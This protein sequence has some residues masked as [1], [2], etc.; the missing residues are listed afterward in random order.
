MLRASDGIYRM[1]TGAIAIVMPS[2][3]ADEA[4][5]LGHR[6]VQ[7]LRERDADAVYGDVETSVVSLDSTNPDAHA[8]LL[9]LG[10]PFSPEFSA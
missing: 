9:A 1:D 4:A 7:A 5:T 10:F 6:I 2:T 8:M 3:R